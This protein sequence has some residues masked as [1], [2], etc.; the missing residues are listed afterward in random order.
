VLRL[1]AALPVVAAVLALTGCA[2]GG[3]SKRAA[4][5]PTSPTTTSPTP[6]CTP[7]PLERRAAEVLMVGLPQVTR[8]DQPLAQEVAELGVGGV[9]VNHDNVQSARQLTDLL[10]GLRKR[11]PAPLLI[12]TDEESGRVSVTRSVVGGGPSARRLAARTPEQIRAFAAGLGGR[13][14]PLGIT[15]DL[16]PSLDLDAGPSDGVIGDRSF[17]PDPAT[18]AQDGLAFALG[19]TDAGLVP[20]VKHFPGQGR[21]TADTHAATAEVTVPLDELRGTDLAPFRHAVDAGA[22][23][24][25][26]NHLSYAA[27][28]ATVPASMSPKAYALLRSTGFDGV[29]MTDSIGMGAVY[30]RW[31]FPE[32]AVTAVAAGAD[33][34]LATDGRQATRM[35]DRLVAAVREGRLPEERLDEAAGRVAALAGG[36][37]RALACS[38]A[39]PRR[40]SGTV[41]PAPPST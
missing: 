10:A 16:A 1:P 35:R 30:P 17:S 18:A 20:T 2:G 19:I 40:L 34:V 27:L 15:M 14:A 9:F 31:D 25:M 38:S 8:A 11:S 41:P 37:P 23:V 4:A 39:S 33:L 26:L 3:T 6:T 28:D 22:P 5:T 32:A 24:V 36:D 13:L 21:S 29:A 7:A 12:S